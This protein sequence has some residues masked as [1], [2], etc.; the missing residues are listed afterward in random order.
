MKPTPFALRPSAASMWV[1]CPGYAHMAA[2]FP[3]QPGDNE[4]REE[5]TAGHWAA[6]EIG[7]GRPVPSGTVAPNGV[8]L[9]DEILDGVQTYLNELFSW[10]VSVYLEFE[11][12]CAQVHQK[13]GG[14]VDSWAWDAAKRLLRVADLKLGYRQVDAFGNFQLL[15]YLVGIAG[16]LKIEGGFD[17]EMIIIQPRA[18]G[19][20]TRKVWKGNSQDLHEWVRRLCAAA[21]N[22][23]AYAEYGAGADK[24]LVSAP[25]GALQTGPHCD[26]C[27]AK[28][29]CPALTQAGLAVVDLSGEVGC[30]TAHTASQVA[31]RLRRLQHAQKVLEATI[32]GMELRLEHEIRNGTPVPHFEIGAGRGRTVYKEGKEQEVITLGKMFGV[33]LAK[34]ERA[35]TPIQAA[36]LL[37]HVAPGVIDG[38][39]EK[40][41][42]KMKLRPLS[43][44]HAEKL[45][46]GN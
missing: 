39:S 15:C 6:Y 18:Y 12:H 5:G 13:C 8:E 26:N 41:S 10:G 35:V 36:A 40:Q 24:L 4:V 30:T 25:A 20:N 42:G 38:Y 27:S 1:A 16:Y 19:F 23:A 28:T 7:H 3:E 11:V 33:D 43:E 9:T 22:A 14:I 45:F 2:R 31:N 34:P 29:H 46:Q 44:N 37:K 32:S 17:F 21:S